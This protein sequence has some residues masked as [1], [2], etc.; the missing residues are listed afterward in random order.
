MEEDSFTLINLAVEGCGHLGKSSEDPHDQITVSVAVKV[1]GGA[2]VRK[3]IVKKRLLWVISVTLA[4][5]LG[6]R[7][8]LYFDH[9]RSNSHPLSFCY[10]RVS[11]NSCISQEMF[12]LPFSVL[13]IPGATELYT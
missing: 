10:K 5:Y 4:G 7:S 1:D 3:E 12:Y 9:S 8:C 11:S 6:M 13:P 2:M